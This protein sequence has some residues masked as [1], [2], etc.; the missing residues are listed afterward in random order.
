[1]RLGE[2]ALGRE[3]GDVAGPVGP[4][5]GVE[6]ERRQIVAA[7]AV[8]TTRSATA[9]PPCRPGSIHLAKEVGSVG[10]DRIRRRRL[11]R[12]DAVADATPRKSPQCIHG[13]STCRMRSRPFA[14]SGDGTT[15]SRAA[16][17]RDRARR[18][19]SSRS[20]PFEAFGQR[21]AG[22]QPAP[23]GG[24]ERQQV[25]VEVAGDGIVA[26][27]L[28]ERLA[29]RERRRGD[30]VRVERRVVGEDDDARVQRGDGA[31]RQRR[32]PSECVATAAG[33]RCR[34]EARARRRGRRVRPARERRR[35][36]SAR[37]GIGGAPPAA[38][39]AVCPGP[40]PTR[41]SQ[42]CST[43]PGET[44][45]VTSGGR[46]SPHPPAQERDQRHRDQ[47]P[48]PAQ[49][50]R[51]RDREQRTKRAAPLADRA[52]TP[53]PAAVAGGSIG[54]AVRRAGGADREGRAVVIEAVAAAAHLGGHELQHLQR[55]ARAGDVAGQR[56]LGTTAGRRT[57]PCAAAFRPPAPGK[58]AGPRSRAPCRFPAPSSPDRRQAAGPGRRQHDAVVPRVKGRLVDRD[59]DR[60]PGAERRHRVGRD[61]GDLRIGLAARGGLLRVALPV[62]LSP[63]GRRL[64]HE[65][66]DGPPGR[67]DDGARGDHRDDVGLPHRGSCAHWECPVARLPSRDRPSGPGARGGSAT[68]TSATTSSSAP[69]G[70]SRIPSDG[71][72]SLLSTPPRK[73]PSGIS[74]APQ[75]IIAATRARIGCGH[76]RVRDRREHQT[77]DAQQR[78]VRVRE[79]P[80]LAARLAGQV[81]LHLEAV[82]RLQRHAERQRD[83][84]QQPAGAQRLA[85]RGIGRLAGAVVIRPPI[86]R[87]G[88]AI[89]ATGGCDPGPAASP[90]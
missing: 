84:Q 2:R 15:C 12:C 26:D 43:S 32:S 58:R 64:Q 59:G 8:A 48:A 70:T 82:Q 77:Q 68:R 7:G 52:A 89:P 54:A 65:V 39:A 72:P 57:G 46:L 13:P 76:V 14:P 74:T 75:R 60:L 44:T 16:C 4:P 9:T 21:S 17:P 36:E 11:D 69:T 3:A 30:R 41:S 49:A 85:D 5:G 23:A 38:T 56:D 42:A 78:P 53:D 79:A 63:A 35:T 27:H 22:V 6:Q 81:G 29:A 24:L 55:A 87:A 73:N 61:R 67:E 50:R 31:R 1:M 51:E 47:R 28:D 18:T 88:A 71:S 90:V 83:R 40:V 20:T 34:D 66:R 19:A 45:D 80:H 10:D 62:L 37:D 33:R 25:E 86:S